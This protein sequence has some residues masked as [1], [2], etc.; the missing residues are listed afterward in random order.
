MGKKL[1]R[2]I[3]LTF[4]LVIGGV[5]LSQWFFNGQ[6][7]DVYS[8]M[9]EKYGFTTV[10]AD[11]QAESETVE[12]NVE[13]STQAPAEEEVKKEVSKKEENRTTE[14]II[15]DYLK[16]H[17]YTDIQTAAIIGNLYQESGLNPAKVEYGNNHEGYGIVQWSYGR[18]QQLF[19]YCDSKGKA[20]DDLDCQL[21]FLIKE[22]KSSQFYQPHLD[23]FNNP[24]SINEATEAYCWGFERPS[25]QYANVQYRKDMAWKAYY[26]NVDR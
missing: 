1:K 16:E 6:Q 2:G 15:W 4:V 25:K 11:V 14:N 3:L 12:E 5:L 26:R 8:S 7:E 20:H 19:S 23:T 13:V 17:G 18:K 10:N 21:E 9:R 22:L 24:Y